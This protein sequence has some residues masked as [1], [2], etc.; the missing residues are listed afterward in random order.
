MSGYRF[1]SGLVG[2]GVLLGFAQPAEAAC[3]YAACTALSTIDRTFTSGTRWRFSV[4]SC[5]CEGLFIRNASFTPR[6]G[7]SRMVLAQGSIAE[8]HVPY[9]VGTPRPL[10]VTQNSDGLGVRANPLSQAECAG[11]TLLANNRICVNLEDRGYAWKSEA[12]FQQGELVSVTM[13]S[14]LGT[15]TYINRWEFH[16]DG[17]IE[18]M[19]GLTGQLAYYGTGG[20]FEPYG[21]RMDSVVN[22]TSSYA[23]T[24]MHNVYYRLDFDIG[25][26]AND[27]VERMT[28]QPSSAPSP[29]STCATPGTC[30]VNVETPILTESAQNIVAETYSTWRIY[31]K[32]LTNSDGRSVGYELVPKLDGLWA[33]QVTTDEPWSEHELWVTR[34]NVCE[35]LAVRNVAPHIKPSC[36]SAPAHVGAMVNGQSVDGQDLV[37]WYV[38]RH[39][40]TP[41]DEDEVNM[42]ID[43]MSFELK[44]RSFHHRNPLEP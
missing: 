12:G 3:N 39:L 13:A 30:W 19:L 42:P 32:Q 22:P 36:T 15:Y 4:Q 27:A 21:S 24:H 7:T 26:S 16:D 35:T 43:W 40:H 18:P 38:N 29:R 23:L 25:G 2:L 8:I 14:Q 33:G 41:R 31:D 17:T 20:A 44:P 5:P 37:V 11:G 1:I 10:D 9:L 28:L 34:Y 6:G